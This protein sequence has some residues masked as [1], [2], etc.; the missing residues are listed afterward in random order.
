MEKLVK[1]IIKDDLVSLN[2]NLPDSLDS[3]L[4]VP[5]QIRHGL[6]N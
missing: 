1:R 2:K 4:R 5:T 3:Q 6:I